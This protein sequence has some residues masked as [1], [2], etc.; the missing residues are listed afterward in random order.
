MMLGFDAVANVPAAQRAQALASGISMA[1]SST[2]WGLLTAIPLLLLHSVLE[3][4][5]SGLL[6]EFD[7]KSTKLVNLIEA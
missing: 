5:S 4:K 2:L 7:E 3:G 6:Q 1:M